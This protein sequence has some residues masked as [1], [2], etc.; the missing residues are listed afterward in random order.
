MKQDRT[1]KGA[2]AVEPE[3]G[4]SRIILLV[5]NDGSHGEALR[6]AW[7][8]LRLSELLHV[9]SKHEDALQFIRNAEKDKD[10]A[11]IAAIVLD[12]DATGE[13]TGGFPP[14]SANMSC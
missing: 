8:Q 2:K 4:T 5:D 9:Y 12:P 3:A 13:E 11:P 7:S 14:R 6:R 1:M 10:A